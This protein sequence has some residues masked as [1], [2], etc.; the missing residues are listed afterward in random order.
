MLHDLHMLVEFHLTGHRQPVH[1]GIQAA[2]TVRQAVR[3]HRDYP[4]HQIHAAAAVKSFFI[5]LRAFTHIIANVGN[6]HAQLVMP[7]LQT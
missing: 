6:M 5:E 4:V 3:Q 1:L 2:D 7:V